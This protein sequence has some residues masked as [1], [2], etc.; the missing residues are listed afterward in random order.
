MTLDDPNSTDQ[1]AEAELALKTLR[2]WAENATPEEVLRWIQRLR[3]FCRN[4]RL[5]ITQI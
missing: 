1:R 5:R 2:A 4:P 3:G